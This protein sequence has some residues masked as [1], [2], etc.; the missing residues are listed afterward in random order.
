MTT[1]IFPGLTVGENIVEA[2]GW[3]G[4][5]DAGLAAM[6]VAFP[7][8]ATPVLKQLIVYFV[9]K[10]RDALFAWARLFTDVTA[11]KFSNAARQATYDTDTLKLKVLA[12]EQGLSSDAYLKA[13]AD[14]KAALSSTLQFLGK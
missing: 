13:R 3:D 9:D 7:W 5:V 11:L 2:V 4:L 14:A 10:Y 8:T 12:V 6:F 1:S